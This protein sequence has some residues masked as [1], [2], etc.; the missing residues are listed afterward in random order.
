MVDIAHM[1]GS[2]MLLQF[3]SDSLVVLD[4]MIYYIGHNLLLDLLDI[5]RLL[6][7]WM[8]L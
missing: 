7:N 4:M 2:M 1:P 6:D 5:V 8:M 3:A